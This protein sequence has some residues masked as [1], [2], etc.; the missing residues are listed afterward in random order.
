MTRRFAFALIALLFVSLVVAACSG[1]DDTTEG[2]GSNTSSEATEVGEPVVNG[3]ALDPVPSSGDDPALG[4]PAPAISST[5]FDGTT[6]ALVEEGTPTIVLVAAHWCPHCQA[7]V[8]V[9]REFYEA[10]G[11]LAEGVDFVILHTWP[12][13][14]RGNWP[15]S[16]WLDGLGDRV[17]LDDAD[18]TAATALGLTGT[19][20]WLVID[21]D[22]NVVERKVGTVSPAQLVEWSE[23]IAPA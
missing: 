5:D 11:A 19:P 22:G 17:V 3:A 15:A 20:M 1:S 9:L 8:E 16:S 21:A 10:D 23:Q 18:G 4:S 6:T 14:E 12:A 13:P 2:S 7:D